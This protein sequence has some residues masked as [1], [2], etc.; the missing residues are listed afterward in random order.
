MGGSGPALL[1]FAFAKG[2]FCCLFIRALSSTCDSSGT[3]GGR[4]LSRVSAGQLVPHFLHT[5]QPHILSSFPSSV[6]VTTSQP[7]GS[8]TGRTGVLGDKGDSIPRGPMLACQ[9]D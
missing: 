7:W 6:L 8:E 9:Q 5:L 2:E 4:P 1:G 3:S